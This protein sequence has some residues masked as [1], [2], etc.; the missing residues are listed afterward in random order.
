L[1][2]GGIAPKIGPLDLFFELGEFKFLDSKVKDAPITG[3]F[4]PLR[5]AND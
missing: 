2:L 3:G 4:D 5:I 1:R